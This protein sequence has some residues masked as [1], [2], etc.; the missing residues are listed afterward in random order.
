MGRIEV[1]G[2]KFDASSQLICV[3]LFSD[4]LESMS[5]DL[6]RCIESNPDVIEWRGD[7]F[8][9]ILDLAQLSKALELFKPCNHSIPLIF[10]FRSFK[11]GGQTDCLDDERRCV[12]NTVIQSHLFD[13]VDIELNSE[14][15]FIREIQKSSEEH[16]CKIIVSHHDFEKS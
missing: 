14:K 9:D 5:E 16:V 7:Y 6:E 15:G 10:T 13:F 2:K 4:N 1:K 8:K 12:I 11:E 3:P